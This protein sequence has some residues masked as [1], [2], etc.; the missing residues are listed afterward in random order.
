[1]AS[2]GSFR[3]WSSGRAVAPATKS[4]LGDILEAMTTI[5][6][7]EEP[8][9]PGSVGLEDATQTT[10]RTADR[11]V[12]VVPR[13]FD[14]VSREAWDGLAAANAWA[15]PFSGWAF[16]RAWWDAYGGR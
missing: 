10:M 9:C 13:R 12:R 6:L 2:R 5:T 3:P 7:G 16:Q 15:T 14:D 4:R 8:A 1:M 11:P